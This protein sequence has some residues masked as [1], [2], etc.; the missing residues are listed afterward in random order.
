[1]MVWN[2]LFML[3]LILSS[4]V[5]PITIYNS[6]L[7]PVSTLPSNTYLTVSIV[8]PPK[9]LALLQQYVQEHKILNFTQVEKLF[10]PK[11][12]ISRIVT[13]LRQMNISAVNYLNV[14]V[15]SGTAAQLEKALKG[16]FYIY[17]FLNHEFYE[18]SGSSIFPN[19]IIIGT[20]ITSLF[21]SKPITLYNITQAVAY[22]V[23]QPNQLRVA[24]NVSWLYEHNITGKGTTIGILDFY[25][26]PYIQ[27]QLESFDSMLNITNPPFLKIVPIGAYNPNDGISTGWAMEISLDVEYAH[28]IAPDAGIVLYVANPNVPLPAIIAY[29]DQQDE[30]NV[31]SQSFGIPELYVDL[32]L[33]PLSYINSLIYE[34]WLGEVEGITF[35]AASGDA[36]GNGYNYFLMPQGSLIFPASIPYVLAVGG[37]SLY[38]SGNTTIQTAWSGE[39]IIGA[40]TGG[41]ST[42]FPAPWYQGISG[43]RL[44]PDVVADANPYTGVYILYYYNQ[45]YLVGGTSLATP[46]VAGIIDLMT[47]QYGKLGFINPYIYE[48]KNSKALTPI[49][50][51]YN[52]PYYVNSTTLNPVTGLGSINAG[53]LYELL[54]KVLGN[55]K[56]SVAV[57]NITYLDGQTVKVVVNISKVFPSSVTGF[58]YNGSS[59]VQQFSL[60]YNGTSW[61][62]EFTAKGSGIEEVIVK[63]SNLTGGTY[64]TVGYQVQFVFPPIALFPEPESIPIILQLMYPNGSIIYSNIPA[65]LTA[66]I[67]KFNPVTNKFSFVSNVALKR[68]EIINLSAFGIQIES[69]Y[70]TGVYQLSSNVSGIYMIKIPGAFGFDE[71]VAGIYVV[72]AVF[73][74]ISAE[75]LVVAPGENVTILAETLALGA[76]NITIGFY[77]SSGDEVYSVPINSI[78]YANTL[79]YI[80]QIKMPY[81]KPGYYTVVAHAIYNGSN[82]TAEGLG[83]TQIYVSPYVLNVKVKLFP[84][85]ILYENQNLTIIANIT[86][87]NGTEVKYGSFSAIIIPSYMSNNFDN[88]ELQY[89]VPLTFVNSSWI[90]K[91]QIPSGETANSFGYSTYGISGYWYV[92]VEGVSSDGLPVNFPSTLNV[93]SLS[94][95]PLIPSQ[96]FIV[97]PYVYVKEFNGTLAF[98]E[99]IEEA[100]II[101][102]NATFINSIIG[103]LIVKNGTVKLINSK[104]VSEKLINSRLIIINSSINS[105]NNVSYISSQIVSNEIKNNSLGFNLV[106]LSIGIILDIITAIIVAIILL[107][108]KFK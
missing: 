73:P 28:I 7:Q 91:L 66:Q 80:A 57:N 87:P 25:G 99:Y 22:S 47:Q 103:K 37:S 68:G 43:Y 95:N 18:F 9:N 76:P 106:V 60:H 42:I 1:M 52:T 50:F 83:V 13:Y 81:L 33:I 32:G 41:Y 56:I 45:T 93:N 48:L 105:Y 88:L 59:V 2:T 98:N 100:V 55:P 92:Y 26:D 69:G 71:F 27:Q 58:I 24:Y 89:S 39:S 29:I 12:E 75:P 10:I 85:D 23:V 38:V 84:D 49:N 44:V 6:H 20:N 14:I 107:R 31:L 5:I 79:L 30:V 51:G 17:R 97:L 90:G 36:G 34:Y 70:L 11:H 102:H 3:F 16:K 82:F 64:I 15:A 78:V 72:D 94:I 77:N 104:V 96:K 8:I 35:V 63:A 108:R 61:I 74:P 62:G 65:N 101:N 53:Y 67:Y 46:I 40:T 4:I 21:L 19:T 54:P 86:Y